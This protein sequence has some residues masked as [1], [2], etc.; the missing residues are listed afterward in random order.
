M[1]SNEFEKADEQEDGNYYSLTGELLK[2]E[3]KAE[4]T[5]HWALAHNYVAI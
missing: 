2:L 5:S 1:W 3:P 4:D